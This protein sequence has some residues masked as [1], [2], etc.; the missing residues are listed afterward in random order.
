MIRRFCGDSFV[1]F[2][3]RWWNGR[4]RVLLRFEGLG[5]HTHVGIV[6]EIERI[7]ECIY[8]DVEIVR[9][10][11]GS[12]AF[13]CNHANLP[14][15]VDDKIDGI[16]ITWSRV[17]RLYGRHSAS[18]AMCGLSIG[19]CVGPGGVDECANE[20]VPIP[21]EYLKDGGGHAISTHS[22]IRRSL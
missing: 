20:C 3:S 13:Q 5:P 7:L 4:P 22:I 6:C 10:I 2:P 11:L 15:S 9:V 14:H 17:I 12:R 19:C 1:R 8:A 21:N 18:L 16:T